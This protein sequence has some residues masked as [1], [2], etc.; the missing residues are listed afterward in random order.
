LNKIYPPQA[1]FFMQFNI[2][3]NSILAR[4]AAWKLKSSRAAI[5]FGRTIH[6][7]NISRQ[8]LLGDTRLLRHELCHVRQ[9]QQYGFLHFL[10]LYLIESIRNG[11]TKNKFEVEA[12]AAEEFDELIG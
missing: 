12:R 11:Y 5:V 8:Q 1:D 4:I 6:L 2:R 9:Y 3:E 7:H 10:V